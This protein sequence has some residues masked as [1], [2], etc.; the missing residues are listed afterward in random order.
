MLYYVPQLLLGEGKMDKRHEGFHCY[1]PNPM[2]IPLYDL[3]FLAGKLGVTTEKLV[4]LMRANANI[5]P[6]PY[7][8]T[9]PAIFSARCL[10]SK[11]EIWGFWKQLKAMG[12]I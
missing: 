2:K 1:R 9:S 11:T 3:E 12:K 4:F 6:K 5:S 10:Y 8:K 7:G